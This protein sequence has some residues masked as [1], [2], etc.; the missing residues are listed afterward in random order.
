[1][2]ANFCNF[3]EYDNNSFFLLNQMFCF[4]KIHS[5]HLTVLRFFTLALAK[6]LSCLS[7]VF[8]YNFVFWYLNSKLYLNHL[9]LI[10]KMLNTALIIYIHINKIYTVLTKFK[11]KINLFECVWLSISKQKT[12]VK[13][14]KKCEKYHKH[15]KNKN[16]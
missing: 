7:M 5:V 2:I 1:M 3:E 12:T 13:L 14:W 16:K 11:P 4:I 15:W 6:S 8:I 9:K 10:C